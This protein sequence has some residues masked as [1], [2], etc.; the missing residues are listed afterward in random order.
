MVEVTLNR[1]VGLDLARTIAI[2]AVVWVHTTNI[3]SGAYGPQ[4]FFIISG[5]LLADF[6]THYTPFEFLLN[7]FLRLFPLAMAMTTIFYF[8]FGSSL[9]F[10]TSFLLLNGFFA[11][12][13]SFPGGW[14]IS[15][16]WIYSWFN[17]I[18]VRLK[19]RAK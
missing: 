18:V 1:S 15:N 13:I 3:Q 8:R 10:L 4:L 17:L 16:E 12:I 11:S 2:M 9:E 19:L 5:Y 6:R 14:S 7:R